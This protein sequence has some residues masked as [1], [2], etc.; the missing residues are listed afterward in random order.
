MALTRG[1]SAASEEWR[2]VLITLGLEGE[3]EAGRD[4]TGPAVT[5]WILR[6]AGNPAA[7]WP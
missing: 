1:N 5:N 2:S 6:G 3:Y 4:Y 7:C